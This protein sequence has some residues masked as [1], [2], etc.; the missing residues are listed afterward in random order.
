MRKLIPLSPVPAGRQGERWG[1]GRF[2]H[3]DI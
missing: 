1:E 3:L 2:G